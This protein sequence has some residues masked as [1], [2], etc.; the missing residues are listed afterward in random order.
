M[1]TVWG[2][3]YSFEKCL[4]ASLCAS[5]STVVVTVDDCGYKENV[6]DSE[7]CGLSRVTRTLVR[8][9]AGR[10]Q[11]EELTTRNRIINGTVL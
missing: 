11:K 8:G 6:F 1:Q 4:T 5:R 10:P 3:P 2:F 9:I 7:V